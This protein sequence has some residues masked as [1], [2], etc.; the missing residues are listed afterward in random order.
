MKSLVE[1]LTPIQQI[2][3]IRHIISGDERFPNNGV[4]PLLIYRK[5]LN[6]QQG[7]DA[8]IVKELF[9]SNGWTN[10]WVDGIYDY[11]HYHSTAH[12]VLAVIK[13]TGRIQFGGPSGISVLLEE[14]DVVIIP[15]GLAHKNISDDRDIVCVGAYPEGQSYDMNYGTE[16]E[17]PS[18]DRNIGKTPIPETDPVYGMNG[19]LVKNW[20]TASDTIEEVL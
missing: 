18:A 8:Q 10:A 17:R 16:H 13:G 12:E 6:I 7:S 15:A 2:N 4:L 5:A 20:V 3:I 1:V 19:P 14:R 9:E 11:H